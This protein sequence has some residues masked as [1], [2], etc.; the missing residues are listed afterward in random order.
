VPDALKMELFE[1][2]NRGNQANLGT[3]GSGIGLA[4]AK[5]VAQSHNATIS[6]Q[7]RDGGGSIFSFMFDQNL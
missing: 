5:S 6:I 7:D 3:K 4:I 2:F 1:R